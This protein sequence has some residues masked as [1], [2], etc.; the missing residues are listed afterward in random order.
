MP[1]RCLIMLL[2]LFHTMHVSVCN[3]V[4]CANSDSL[5]ENE[6]M[7]SMNW[8]PTVPTP[9]S[10][11]LR[12]VVHVLAAPRALQ[13][14]P[15]ILQF[16]WVHFLCCHVKQFKMKSVLYT[17][18]GAQLIVDVDRLCPSGYNYSHGWQTVIMFHR[19]MLYLVACVQREGIRCEELEWRLTGMKTRYMTSVLCIRK[20]IW[21]M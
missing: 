10:V 1:L 7:S 4:R 6:C 13:F 2:L 8:H 16:K 14:Q 9:V 21:I 11:C 3:V 12:T 17:G 20:L 5:L 19:N 15:L 18:D